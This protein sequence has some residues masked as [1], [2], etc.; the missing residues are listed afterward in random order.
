MIQPTGIIN[1]KDSAEKHISKMN[2]KI[3]SVVDSAWEGRQPLDFYS[4]Q[5]SSVKMVHT[6]QAVSE[7]TKAWVAKL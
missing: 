2:T 3:T 1:Q 7:T 6:A 5:C 4:L